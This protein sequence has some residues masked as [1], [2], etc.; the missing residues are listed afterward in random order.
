METVPGFNEGLVSG[1][2]EPDRIV[3]DRE[4]GKVISRDIL[5]RESGFDAEAPLKEALVEE[6]VET[7]LRLEGEFG[8]PLDMEWTVA[9]EKV[10]IL[11][12]RPVTA[13]E[14]GPDTGEGEADQRPWYRTLTKTFA[15][16]GQIR[17]KIQDELLPDLEASIRTLGE[18]DLEALDDPALAAETEARW[19]LTERWD[20]LYRDY[21]IPF[22]HGVRLFGSLY[23]RAVQPE[24]PFEFIEL[25]VHDDFRSLRRNRQLQNLAAAL[26]DFS[27]PPSP[28]AMPASWQKDREAFI[29]EYGQSSF[30][31][32]LIFDDSRRFMEFLFALSRAGASSAAE[33]QAPRRKAL[34]G[35]FLGALEALGRQDGEDI[36]AMARLSYRLRDDDNLAVARI[37]GEY[38]RAHREGERRKGGAGE[39][40]AGAAAPG[41]SRAE[42]AS[43]YRVVS[44]QVTGTAAGPGLASG[45]ARVVT[46]P[47]DLFQVRQGEILVCDSIDPNITFVVP[48]VAGIVERRGGMLIHGAI[49]AREYGIPCVTG[50]AGAVD[51]IAPGDRVTVDGFSGIV[52]I[53]RDEDRGHG[54]PG[55]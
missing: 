15:E 32:A 13:G 51:I 22:A 2:V 16:L 11:Q 31:E 42:T 34:E 25:L 27:E 28:D 21:F 6:I 30:F 18:T 37:R 4:S 33:D 46:G 52:T 19:A 43:G 48:L 17:D 54:L 3:V 7:G 38:L 12:V 40:R 24:S 10:Y 35:G 44:R 55:R 14:D 45:P 20:G 36:L 29:L 47:E 23:S 41:E 49:I 53:H 26:K 39:A 1:E 50:V 5:I 9:G 8:Y